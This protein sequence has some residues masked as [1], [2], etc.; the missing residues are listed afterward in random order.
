MTTMRRF[1]PTE[2]YGA[3]RVIVGVDDGERITI[4]VPHALGE[5]NARQLAE[6]Q[7]RAAGHYD[8]QALDA[9]RAE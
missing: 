6:E 3:F 5:I 1:T 9:E 2:E 4:T 8:V 7:A